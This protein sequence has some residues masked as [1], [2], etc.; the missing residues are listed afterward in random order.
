MEKE[1]DE[2][3][4]FAD[5]NAANRDWYTQREWDRVVGWGLVPKKY[6]PECKYNPTV[7]EP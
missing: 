4:D 6:S 7:T 1:W 2:K 3:K 5:T